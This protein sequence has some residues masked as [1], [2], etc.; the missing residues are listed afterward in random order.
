MSLYRVFCC[1]L[2]VA[3]CYLSFRRGRQHAHRYGCSKVGY[4]DTYLKGN[5]YRYRITRYNAL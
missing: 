4:V 1:V 2:F 5:N 3:N